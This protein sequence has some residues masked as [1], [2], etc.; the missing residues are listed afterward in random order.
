MRAFP[1]IPDWDQI[2][3]WYDAMIR[4]NALRGVDPDILEMMS[5]FENLLG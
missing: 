2:Q 1:F 3:P 5:V 4:E